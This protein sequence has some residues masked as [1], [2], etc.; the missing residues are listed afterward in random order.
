VTTRRV[1]HPGAHTG[2]AQRAGVRAHGGTLL[3]GGVVGDGRYRLLAQ[4]GVDQ[5]GAAHLWRARDGQLR[6]DVAL[7][8]IIGDPSDTSA[9]Q[10]ARKTLD[11]AAHAARFSHPAVSRVLDVL[12]LGNGV[13]ANEGVLGMVVADWSQGTDLIDLIAEH[14]LP[15]TTAIRLLEPLASAVEQAHHQGLVLGVDHPQRIRVGGDGM[16]RLA[17]PGPLPEA[18][19]RD[20]V[21]GLGAILYL[22]LTGHW[23]LQGGPEGVPMA[24]VGPDGRVLPPHA[25]V[26][27]VPGDLSMASVRSIE[28]T[29][30]GGIRTSAALMNVLQQVSAAETATEL[31]QPI[32]DAE[33]DDG[34]IW[35]TRR[36]VQDADRRKK[37]A[38]GVTLLAVATVGILAWVGM[39]LISFFSDDSGP[40]GGPAAVV[41]QQTQ[42]PPKTTKPAP[43]KPAGPLQPGSLNEYNIAEGPDNPTKVSRAIDGDPGSGWKTSI[44]KQQLPTFKP[45]IGLVAAFTEPAK[46]AQ[47]TIDS[48]SEGTVVE[49]RTADSDN[50][51]F[52]ATK[53]ITTVTLKS[54]HNEINLPA[55]TQSQ[56]VIIWL[57]KLSE[58][59]KGFVSEL[60]EV[61]FQR[62]G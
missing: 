39:Q 3:P 9:V 2:G 26:P 16:L 56:H 30:I 55:G 45:G 27:A 46:L 36:P 43:P 40:T 20:D 17:F 8:I 49:I 5:R 25:L 1:D 24:P 6:R 44:Y 50:P 59:D 60:T 14:P 13:T 35:T 11:R 62:A 21:K 33:D 7:T 42:A 41:N 61:A 32:E 29:S 28:D 52:N 4:F 15:P 53:L 38:I 47:I 22:L 58:T 48:P 12:T 57:T 34:T 51:D 23:S 18:T 19:L 54:G 37:L 10:D 31:M